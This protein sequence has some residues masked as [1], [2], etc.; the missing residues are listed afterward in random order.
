MIEA[1]ERGFPQSEIAGAS[2]EFQHKV[3]S[4]EA[5]V[6][7]VNRYRVAEEKPIETLRIDRSA[8][9]LQT[10]KLHEVRKTRNNG[11]VERSL[12]TLRRMAASG[13]ETAGSQNLMPPLLD[14]V[15]C[16][17]TLG[18]I[19]GALREVFGTYDERPHI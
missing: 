5:V 11:D 16:Y 4:G 1:I 15:S 6:V 3:E 7:G 9:D 13:T 14:A 19:C 10:G 12:H 18:E 2:Y 17:A 8:Q